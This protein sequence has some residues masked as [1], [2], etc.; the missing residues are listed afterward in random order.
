[1]EGAM[2]E[3]HAA[4]VAVSEDGNVTIIA[5][6]TNDKNVKLVIDEEG[7]VLCI[8]H[9]GFPGLYYASVEVSYE[10]DIKWTIG[11]PIYV[12]Q[13]GSLQYIRD[14]RTRYRGAL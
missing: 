10:L 13:P 12:F 9:E 4:I 11:E 8:T 5:L 1:M 7:D 6:L 3:K 14:R 2:S